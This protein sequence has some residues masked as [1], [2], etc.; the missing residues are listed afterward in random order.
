MHE[1]VGEIDWRDCARKFCDLVPGDKVDDDTGRKVAP[2]LAARRIG[3]GD[4]NVS[5]LGRLPDPKMLRFPN[6]EFR[7]FDL[8]KVRHR[9]EGRGH[10]LEAKRTTN[11]AERL[12]RLP[13]RV[14][15]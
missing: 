13:I 4:V 14:V 12:D 15:P 6:G 8:A 7:A 5:L 11:G 9:R 1:I 3:G 2:L 10:R